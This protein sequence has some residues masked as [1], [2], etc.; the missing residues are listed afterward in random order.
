MNAS[1]PSDEQSRTWDTDRTS[2]PSRYPEFDQAASAAYRRPFGESVEAPDYIHKA[3]EVAPDHWIAMVDPAWQ[4]EGPPPSWS[5]VGR[6]RSGPDGTIQEWQENTEYRPSPAARGWPDPTD[7]VDAAI[8]LASTGYGTAEEVHRSLA[9]AE[10]S[11]WVAADGTPLTGAAPDGTPV[12]PVH[13]STAQLQGEGQ[14]LSEVSSVADLLLQLPE[15]HRLFVNPSGAVSLLVE[16]E[17]LRKAV[18]VHL[19]A[20]DTGSDAAPDLPGMD[21]AVTGA[22]PEA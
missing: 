4:G 19:A 20:A 9:A 3:A 18:D 16:T 22:A 10:V 13:S 5:L 11:F 17:P 6:W 12:L 14:L 8:Q 7:P 2:P 21:A 15:G 1:Q